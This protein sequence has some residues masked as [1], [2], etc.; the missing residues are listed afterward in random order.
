MSTRCGVTTGPALGAQPRH[1][2]QHLQIKECL[3]TLF[4]SYVLSKMP[5]APHCYTHVSFSMRA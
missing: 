2:F 1:S 4:V 3:S 5:G